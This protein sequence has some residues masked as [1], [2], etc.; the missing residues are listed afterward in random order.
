MFTWG[1]LAGAMAFIPDIAKYTGISTCTFSTT[2]DFA[3]RG[4]SGVFSLASSSC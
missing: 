2:K 4:R 3:G 1:I